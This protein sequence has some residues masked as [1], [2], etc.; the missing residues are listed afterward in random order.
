MKKNLTFIGI[1]LLFVGNI[2]AQNGQNIVFDLTKKNKK[3]A[4]DNMRVGKTGTRGAGSFTTTEL[5][6]E[7]KNPE[8]FIAFSM[9]IEGN[10]LVASLITIELQTK[11]NDK[12]SDWQTVEA[13]HDFEQNPKKYVSNMLELDKSTTAIRLKTTSK[14]AEMQPKL[15]KIRLFAA[16][17]ISTGSVNNLTPEGICTKPEVVSRKVWGGGLGLTDDKIYIGTPTIVTV[18]HLIVHHGAS[19]NTSTNWAGVVASYFDYHVNNNGWS[20]IGYN[21]L[22]APDGTAFVGRGG[23]ENVQGAHMCGRNANTM[24]ICMIGNFEAGQGAAPQTA[25]VDKLVKILAWKASL[26]NID[27]MGSSS[28]ASYGL[29]LANVCG[30]RDGCLDAYTECPGSLLWAQ[31]PTIRQRVKDAVAACATATNDLFTE[32]SVKISPNPNNGQFQISAVLKEKSEGLPLFLT[33]YDLNGKVIFEK[34][35]DNAGLD[36]NQIVQLP[37]V[38]KGLYLVRLRSGDKAFSEKIQVF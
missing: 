1:C 8:P 14:T 13:S 16:G 27:P 18:T 25:A 5:A 20:D 33:V 15:L 12:W 3:I 7:L 32:G 35:T 29:N 22:V 17:N 24:G 37:N 6:V 30:H 2:F 10:Y 36:F 23:G 34:K 26:N 28:L 4:L 11:S 9:T 38:A 31:L 21:Y 19:S